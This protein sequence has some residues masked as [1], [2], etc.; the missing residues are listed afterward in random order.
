MDDFFGASA[1]PQVQQLQ[2]PNQE[3][4]QASPEPAQNLN[5]SG[6]NQGRHLK[7]SILDTFFKI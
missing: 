3:V 6:S 4:R 7:I 1:Q 5:N 2:P